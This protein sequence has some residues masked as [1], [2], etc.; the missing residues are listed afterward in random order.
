MTT[1]YRGESEIEQSLARDFK[2]E[3]AA[4]DELRDA[5]MA[6][7]EPWSGRSGDGNADRIF[8]LE[9]GRSTKTYR[10]S[11]ALARI[12]YGEQAAMLNRVLFE[13]M[14]VARWINENEDI[15]VERFPRALKLEDYLMVERIKSTGWLE[16][17]ER[18]DIDLDE[19]EL[20]ELRQDFGTYNERL[21][22]GHDNI[23]SLLDDIRGQFDEDEWTM[24]QNYVRT[25]HQ[26]NNQLLHSTVGG[27]RQAYVDLQDG[28][29]GIWTGPSDAMIGRVLFS[30]HMIYRQAVAL[31]AERFELA[32][33]DDLDELFERTG[34]A[35]IRLPD[36]DLKDV[37]RNDP[38]PCESGKKLKHCHGA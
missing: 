20:V 35:F 4:C 17:A 30:A 9:I 19:E 34:R 10:G 22:T 8:L 14:A 33:G 23:R 3:L 15:A 13:S 27:L 6:R 24:I 37:G 12:G 38:C 26:E 36:D 29:Y 5:Y 18:I 7:C 31:L 1:T 28:G 11:V 16:P 2:R 32:D 21:W 25:G